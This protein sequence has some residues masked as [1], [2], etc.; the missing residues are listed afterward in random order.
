MYGGYQLVKNSFNEFAILFRTLFSAG[1]RFREDKLWTDVKLVQLWSRWRG[2]TP[3]PMP[4]TSTS[5][6]GTLSCC[7]VRPWLPHIVNIIVRSSNHVSKICGKEKL[8]TI[9]QIYIYRWLKVR[10][11][12]Y[13]S[14]IAPFLYVF[15][16]VS[17]FNSGSE[18]FLLCRIMNEKA[19]FLRG[20]QP[21]GWIN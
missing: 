20:R 16:K 21:V 10:M 15:K 13:F 14:A 12:H 2:T 9:D 4:C 5:D 6:S 19:R 11:L 3:S 18:Y 1:Y 7:H 8:D 17:A